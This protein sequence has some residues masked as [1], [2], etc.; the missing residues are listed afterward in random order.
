MVFFVKFVLFISTLLR[1][2]VIYKKNILQKFKRF[3]IESSTN[4]TGPVPTQELEF[5]P[6]EHKSNYTILSLPML[7]NSRQIP[8]YN[9]ADNN[10]ESARS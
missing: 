1:L 7:Q 4:H 6:E 3:V 10:E 2:C 9:V 8:Y 5:L